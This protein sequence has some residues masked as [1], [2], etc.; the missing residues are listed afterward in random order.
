MIKIIENTVTV[1][2]Y[3]VFVTRYKYIKLLFLK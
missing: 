1:G 3:D 2:G